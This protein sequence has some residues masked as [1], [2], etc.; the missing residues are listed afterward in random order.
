MSRGLERD[1]GRLGTEGDRASYLGRGEPSSSSSSPSCKGLSSEGVKGGGGRGPEGVGGC[2]A[3][4]HCCVSRPYKSTELTSGLKIHPAVASAAR[5][6]NHE[7][8]ALFPLPL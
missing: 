5:S 8:I 7:S 6:G 4:L 2:L 3:E 1:R